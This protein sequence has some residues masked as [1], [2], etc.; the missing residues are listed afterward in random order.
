MTARASA[1]GLRAAEYA[2]AVKTRYLAVHDY[3]MGGIW[4]YVLASN[5]EEIT[6]RYPEV[7]VVEEYPSWMTDELR[8]GLER[9]VEDIDGP[10]RLGLLG[11][12]LR[13]RNPPQRPTNADRLLKWHRETRGV[14]WADDDGVEMRLLAAGHMST[15][16]SLAGTDLEGVQFDPVTIARDEDDWVRAWVTEGVWVAESGPLNDDEAH[17]LFLDWVD[18]HR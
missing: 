13:D 4:G 11:I 14:D 18:S 2:E 1:N 12:V 10:R 17:G 6:E 16:I 9:R 7:K 5:P 3:G 8:E 15:R